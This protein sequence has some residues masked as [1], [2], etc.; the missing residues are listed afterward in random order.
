MSNTAPTPDKDPDARSG[1]KSASF[2]MP[3]LLAAVVL[4]GLGFAVSKIRANRLPAMERADFEAARARWEEAKVESYE[5]AVTVSGMQPGNYEVTVQDNLATSATFDGRAL[6][7]QRTFGT[8]AVT[9]MFDTLSRDLETNDKDGNL[10]LQAEFDPEY[11]YPTK[12]ARIQLTTGHHDALQ[13]EVTKF[14][15]N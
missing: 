10:M 12:Y 5:I 6:K 1:G 11:G 9:G 4:A 2:L 7:R 8:W 15:K 13:W 14:I 3:I